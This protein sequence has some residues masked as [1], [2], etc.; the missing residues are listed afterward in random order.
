MVTNPVEKKIKPRETRI[1]YE[2]YYHTLPHNDDMYTLN[3]VALTMMQLDAHG[4]YVRALRC[5]TV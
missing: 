2:I 4:L 1:E 5:S 3:S